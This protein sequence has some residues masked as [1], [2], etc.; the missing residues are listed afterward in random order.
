MSKHTPGSWKAH[1]ASSVV[2]AL[3]SYGDISKG[4]SVCAVL[5]QRDIL[6]TKANA[7]LIAA[8]PDLLKAAQSAN[9]H[10]I[11]LKAYLATCATQVI[12]ENL[13]TTIAALRVQAE[14]LEAAIRKAAGDR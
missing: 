11:G 12:I 14:E 5:P 8:A 2:G 10:M 9:R 7:F 4:E 3:V 1:P 6:E 13:E